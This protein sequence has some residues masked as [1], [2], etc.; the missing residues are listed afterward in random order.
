MVKTTSSLLRPEI[1]KSKG[2]TFFFAV[3]Y[4][5]CG[6]DLF[7]ATRVNGFNFRW[8]QLLL[9]LA[10]IPAG[11]DFIKSLR[12]KNISGD[13]RPKILMGWLP[14]FVVYGLAALFSA[15]PFLTGIK[16]GW[17]LFNIGLAALVC[18]QPR[19]NETIEKGFAWGIL[20]TAILL[21]LQAL[22]LYALPFLTL[23]HDQGEGSPSVV[24][25]CSIFL[26]YAQSSFNFNGLA[27]FRPHAFYYEPSYVGAALS[28]ALFLL[29][30]LDLKRKTRGMGF[31]PAIAL[32]S[33]LL[34]SSRTGILS[35][36]LFLSLVFYFS[37]RNPDLSLLG[38]SLTRALLVSL[39]LIGAFCLFPLGRQY[40]EF[41]SG[42]LGA[43][44]YMRLHKKNS[45]EQGRLENMRESLRLISE[46]PL[47]GNGVTKIVPANT[48]GL[49]Q[50]SGVTWFE[51]GLESGIL[52]MAAFLFAVL[53]NMRL[54][55]D[56]APPSLLRNL[57]L[58][59]WIVHFG[60]QLFFSQTFPRLDYWLLFFLSLRLLFDSALS[61]GGQSF[62]PGTS[63]NPL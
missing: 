2:Q 62:P 57:V 5:L 34:C 32:S 16:W 22:A 42:P 61:S 60:F 45:S 47:L 24:S 14:F 28:F 9:L 29:I 25:F 37:R 7:F 4:F 31:F 13:L 44:S 56:K 39:I 38:K 15:T 46:H 3:L 27:I 18:L 10:A 63:T 40:V 48:E 58:S 19:R 11:F 36:V 6:A 1:L 21:W 33:I 20:A 49:S 50:F 59:A 43:D 55:W 35:V 23:V 52:G 26:G 54:A 41:I 51:I 8:G 17:G 30:F 12:E 53:A